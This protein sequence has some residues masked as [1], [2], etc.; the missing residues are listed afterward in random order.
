MVVCD[1]KVLIKKPCRPLAEIPV[2]DAGIEKAKVDA[3]RDA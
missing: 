1:H 2:A 3:G